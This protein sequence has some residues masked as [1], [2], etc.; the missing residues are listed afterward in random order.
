[1]TEAPKE[2]VFFFYI[3]TRNITCFKFNSVI[4]Y[5]R[6]MLRINS[7]TKI[8]SS[9][10]NVCIRLQLQPCLNVS[11]NIIAYYGLST[12]CFHEGSELVEVS[13]QLM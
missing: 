11:N 13:V 12:A 5:S 1:M 6:S 7:V 3:H 2:R 9:Y 10:C 8:E 4:L